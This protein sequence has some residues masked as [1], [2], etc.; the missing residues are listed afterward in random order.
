MQ[1][2]AEKVIVTMFT[3]ESLNMMMANKMITLP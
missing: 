2:R 1:I 3:Y